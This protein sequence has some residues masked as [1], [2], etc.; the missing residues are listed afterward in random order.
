MSGR[1]AEDGLAEEG[2]TGRTGEEFP[3]PRPAGGIVIGTMTGGAAAVGDRATAEDRAGRAGPPSAGP[4]PAGWPPT[5]VPPV[6]PGGIGV[7]AMTGGAVAAGAG[8]RAVHGTEGAAEVPPELL[9]AV[10]ALREE[11]APLPPSTATEEV[12][13]ALGEVEEE[14][15]DGAGAADRERLGRLRGRLEAAATA[16]GGLASAVALAQAIGQFL[17]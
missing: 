16:V 8:A 13:A 9:A 5:A 3:A 14:L 15:A 11:L 17:A 2:R 1:D 12:A 7:G 4:P 10:R 6:V